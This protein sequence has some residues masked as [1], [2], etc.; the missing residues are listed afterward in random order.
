MNI[1]FGPAGVGGVKEIPKR[2]KEYEKLGIKAAEIP[3]TYQVWIKDKKT[4]AKIKDYADKSGVELSI[5]A[6]YWIN[7]NSKDKIKKEKSKKRILRCCEVANWLNVKRVV[8]HC[9]YY[10][11][12]SKEK[13]YLNIKESILDIKERVKKNKWQ[14][15]LC[16]EIMGKKNVFGSISEISELVKEA[17]C[18]FCI[19]FAHVLARYGNYKVQ[20]LKKAFP[21]KKWH[22]HFSGIEY[23]EKGEKRH[24]KTKKKR[25]KEL[26]KL[27]PKNK[28]ITI[29]NESPFPIKDSILSI[30]TFEL[31]KRK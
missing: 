29:I 25:I 1:K 3:F 6:P 13:S 18:S 20:E 30:K 8:F 10:G 12:M 27:L 24:I 31:M 5:H 21:Q 15:K 14:V 19:D 16:P 2:L 4:A 9:G 22:C 17:K 23:G 26:L 7:L 11:G 28:Q